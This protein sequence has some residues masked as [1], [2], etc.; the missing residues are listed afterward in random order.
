M[1]QAKLKIWLLAA[2]PKTLPA[3]VG[4]VL[5]GSAMAYSEGGFNVLVFLVTVLAALLIQV[6]TNFANDYYD[7]VKG[8]DTTDRSGP[9]RATQAGLVTPAEMK[10]AFVVTFLAALVLGCYLVYT[11]GI[12]IAVIGI[13]SILCGILYTGGPYPLGYIGLGDVFVLIFFG[14]IAVGGTYFLQTGSIKA[15][16]ILAGLAPGLLSTAI[17]VVNNFRDVHTDRTVGKKTL[18]VRFGYRFTVVEYIS[19]IAGACL[20]P[21]V[22]CLC[23][24]GH[25][26]CLISLFTLVPACR[27]IR[28]FIS[29]PDA[30]VLNEL[31][32]DTGKLLAIFCVLFSVGWIL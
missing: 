16:V 19:S 9:V 25:Y 2:R 22:L 23:I 1:D 12:A 5:V 30:A 26:M 32:A 4:P 6:G 14:P 29:G 11:G 3:A 18:A 10:Q 28:I 27:C 20:I 7:Y 13:V 15:T 24:R 31:L 21:I 8:A 17:L